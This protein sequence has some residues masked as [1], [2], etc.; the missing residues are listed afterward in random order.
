M[1]D[2]WDLDTETIRRDEVRATIALAIVALR[3]GEEPATDTP[4]QRDVAKVAKPIWAN[5]DVRAQLHQMRLRVRQ[6]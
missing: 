2:T 6:P 1:A 3:R 4:L 5:R